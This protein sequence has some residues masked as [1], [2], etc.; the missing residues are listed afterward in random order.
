M[1][2]AQPRLRGV[3]AGKVPCSDETAKGAL[4]EWGSCSGGGCAA[5]VVHVQQR[6]G[7]R[8]L[9]TQ[10]KRSTLERGQSKRTRRLSSA[11]TSLAAQAGRPTGSMHVTGTTL[12]AAIIIAVGV[13]AVLVG[14][15]IA[16]TKESTLARSRFRRFVTHRVTIASFAALAAGCLAGMVVLG[17]FTFAPNVTALSSIGVPQLSASYSGSLT[18]T[19][20]GISATM[21]LQSVQQ[22]GNAISG[23]FQV[24]A[25]LVGS[26][27]F[28]GTVDAQRNITFD[29]PN[30]TGT[31]AYDIK[32][33]GTVAAD[34][35][36][37]GAYVVHH[38]NGRQDEQGTWNVRP[39]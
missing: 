31:D 32:F 14:I 19:T 5:G 37:S 11:R 36:M 30:G 35:S 24:G 15:L 21:A 33:T 18:N 1:G 10:P 2:L 17:V 7:S 25:P 16:T 13:L 23:N 26:G 22:H 4:R 20:A 39:G 29:V 34:G 9:T 38:Q 28:T 27:D 12:L 8:P 3:A 6:S